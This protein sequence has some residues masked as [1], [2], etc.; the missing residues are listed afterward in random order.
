MSGRLVRTLASGILTT[1]E[2][3]ATWDGQDDAGHPLASGVY[4]FQLRGSDFVETQRV[5]LIK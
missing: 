3:L 4:L 1:G 5:A 2:H